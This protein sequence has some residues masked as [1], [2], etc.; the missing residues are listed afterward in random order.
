M[1]SAS[2]PVFDPYRVSSNDPAYTDAE[3]EETHQEGFGSMNKVLDPIIDNYIKYF[4]PAGRS[5]V[6]DVG[7]RDARDAI[8]IGKRM[9]LVQGKTVAV[10]ANPRAANSIR[11]SYPWIEVIECAV[12]DVNGDADFIVYRGDEGAAGSSSLNLQWKKDDLKG[13]IVRVQMRRLDD[14]VGDEIIDVMKLDVEGYSLKALIGLGE[15]ISQV[16][17]FH[18]ETEEWTQSDIL[19]K[20]YMADHGFKLVDERQEWSGMPDLTFINKAMVK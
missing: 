2:Q 8:E 19:V 5:V 13:D 15:K 11:S 3:N 20:Q 12:A 14:L 16:K 9:S 10:E 1:S 7:S 4:G 6:W 18:I 17:C